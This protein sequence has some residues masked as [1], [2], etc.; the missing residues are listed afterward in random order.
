MSD[1]FSFVVFN[2]KTRKMSKTRKTLLISFLAAAFILA[3]TGSYAKIAHWSNMMCCALV[4]IGLVFIIAALVVVM[5]RPK[6][7]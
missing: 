3:G 1:V 5:R 7:N 6:M 4:F 2:V